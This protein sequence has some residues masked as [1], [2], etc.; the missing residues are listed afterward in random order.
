MRALTQEPVRSFSS[1]LQ[2][3]STV[4]TGPSPFSPAMVRQSHSADSIS[5]DPRRAAGTPTESVTMRRYDECTH[6]SPVESFVRKSET[7]KGTRFLQM[8]MDSAQHTGSVLEDLGRLED[9]WDG[10]LESKL[11]A[12]ATT[13][14]HTNS[15]K[16]RKPP[17]QRIYGDI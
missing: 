11:S 16:F 10:Q 2:T 13:P 17:R 15:E 7:P 12:T 9:E 14:R 4:E 6:R 1:G 5:V 3:S 8:S